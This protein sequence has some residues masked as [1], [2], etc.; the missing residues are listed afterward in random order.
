MGVR[1]KKRDQKCISATELMGV[2]IK[3]GKIQLIIIVMDIFHFLLP[4]KY[5]IV[6]QTWAKEQEA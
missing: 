6:C 4:Q 5:R 1:M 2:K 3:K